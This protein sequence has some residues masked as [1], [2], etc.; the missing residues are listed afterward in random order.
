VLAAIRPDEVNFPLL[1]HV[2]G[3]M[4]LVGALFA[5]GVAILAAR[6]R[7]DE[8]ESVGLTRFGLWTLIAGVLPSYVL[9]RIGA[10]WTA[11]EE[12]LSDDLELTWLE[13]GYITAD[14]GAL[15]I[16]ISIILSV[17]G[18]RGLRSGR[19][20]GLAT[21]VGAI[22]LLLVAAYVVA[23]WAMTAKPD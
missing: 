14:V 10:Q 12:N 11:S 1:L 21:A 13:I 17:I 15:L 8:A 7:S 9:M 16:L 2:L 3:A 22:A 5:V 20:R 4:L 18:L 19:G 23:V 6:R